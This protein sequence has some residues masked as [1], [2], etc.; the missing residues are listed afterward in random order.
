MEDK[1][2]KLF[3]ESVD[4]VVP[5]KQVEMVLESKK[6][7]ATPRQRYLDEQR[8][9]D[10]LLDEPAHLSS[11]ETG[12][13]L[14]FSRPGFQNKGLKKLRKGQYT[15]EAKLDLHGLIVVEAKKALISFIRHCHNKGFRCVKI[16][17]GKG[18]GSKDG[19]AV[20]KSN[21]SY[22]LQQREDTLAFCSAL[23][24][25]GGTGAI[26]LLLRKG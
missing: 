13:E 19:K 25:D 3:R 8:V 4:G 6:P 15:V 5:L 20:I 23:P 24:N 1:D 17:H 16:I 10:E 11:I 22:W 18:L 21:L 9:L 2:R 14:I 12:E 7:K 26:Y